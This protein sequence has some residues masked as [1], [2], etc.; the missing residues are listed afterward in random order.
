[1]PLFSSA[2]ESQVLSASSE[3]VYRFILIRILFAPPLYSLTSAIALK[4][5]VNTLR[6]G[7]VKL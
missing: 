4:S 3:K 1:M 2:S 7:S 6:L 5:L